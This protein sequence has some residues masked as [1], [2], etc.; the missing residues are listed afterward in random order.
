MG[1]GKQ[2]FLQL[3]E[4]RTNLKP[5]ESLEDREKAEWM[6]DLMTVQYEHEKG[7]IENYG[8]SKLGSLFE[9]DAYAT[10]KS[11]PGMGNPSFPSGGGGAASFDTQTPGSGD[12]VPTLLPVA[13]Q[14]AGNTIGFDLVP[15]VQ[16]NAPWGMLT[17]FDGVYA[18]GTVDGQG[19]NAP[20]IF[21]VG[22]TGSASFTIDQVVTAQN[23]TDSGATA[24]V[25]FVGKDRISGD[26]IFR[27]DDLDN[28]LSL[29]DVLT[30]N[31]SPDATIDGHEVTDKPELVE[32]L[33]NHLT[34]FSGSSWT[35]PTPYSRDEG[36]DTM[37]NNMGLQI[38]SRTV[39]MRTFQASINVTWEQVQDLRHLG[40]D[41]VSKSK[42]I[43]ANEMTQ[44]INKYILD[45]AFKLGVSNHYNVYT[46]EGI[47]F[48]LNIGATD[49]TLNEMGFEDT[50]FKGRDNNVTFDTSTV[51]V[52]GTEPNQ[53]STSENFH[54]RQRRIPSRI[55]AASNL[56]ANRSR[57][58][59]ATWAVLNMK[60]ASTLQDVSGFTPAPAENNFQQGKGNVY[61][62]GEY[63]GVNV[64]VDTNMTWDDQRICV[65]S[66][67]D[68]ES[69]GLILMTYLMGES[70]DL[71][72]EGTA[73]PKVVMKSRLQ[74]VEAGF[75]PE[76]RYLTFGVDS[77][78]G[79]LF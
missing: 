9:A 53:K 69:P 72:A 18:G 5:N 13:M 7:I 75:H 12:P 39:Y 38:F 63:M 1:Y 34:G 73:A 55:L 52:K 44:D 37:P 17:Y 48:H 47:N 64:Y 51:S 57:Q 6:S 43:L 15:K 31:G 67:G 8:P 23:N 79:D 26:Y 58:G 27:V 77:A 59:R 36:E 50:D 30:T 76:T 28:D 10:V 22:M 29:S 46:N 49:R 78:V 54:T 65:G 2:D 42:S 32:A 66:K 74:L 24:N 35:D 56:I 3:I 70:V 11:T 60:M 33:N 40:I 61:K 20:V 19:K 71:V 68:E 4:K 62:L 14:V 21:K 16:A 45:R 41:A 25:A